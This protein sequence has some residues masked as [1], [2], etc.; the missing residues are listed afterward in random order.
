MNNIDLKLFY[1]TQKE[2]A[3][4]KLLLTCEEGKEYNCKSKTPKIE[5]PLQSNN[6]S[7][8]GSLLKFAAIVLFIEPLYENL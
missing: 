8:L 7:Y 2:D 4:I 6:K 1:E 5:I 3:D